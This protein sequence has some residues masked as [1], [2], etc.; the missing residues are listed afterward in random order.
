MGIITKNE[1]I[2]VNDKMQTNV[3]GVFACGNITGGLLQVSKAVYEGEK[4]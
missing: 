3:P 2:V 1:T 4:A